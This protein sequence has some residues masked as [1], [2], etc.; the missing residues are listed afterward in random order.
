MLNQSSSAGISPL[1]TPV[2]QR[3]IKDPTSYKTEKILVTPDIA[4]EWLTTRFYSGQ[5]SLRSQWVNYLSEEM[6]KGNFLQGTAVHFSVEGPEN[7]VMLI[8]GQHTLSAI[9][10]CKIPQLLTT[11]YI[12]SEGKDQTAQYYYSIDMQARR[13]ATDM[14]SAINLADELVIPQSLLGKLSAAV[15]MI[16]SKFI[17]YRNEN[18]H[19]DDVLRL[20]RE[21][22]ESMNRYMDCISGASSNMKHLAFRRATLSVALV[23]FHFSSKRVGDEKIID[24]WKGVIID[25]AIGKDDVR[26]I[27]NRHLQTSVSPTENKP[28]STKKTVSY[29]YSARYIAKCFNWFVSEHKPSEKTPSFFQVDPMS[30]IK[31]VGSPFVGNQ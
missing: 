15:K 9:I 1:F 25:D 7:K 5:R 14:F 18:F 22:S 17:P 31:I 10:N 24:F 8:N 23:T 13:T 21:Y 29:I 2:S 20:M 4:R 19:S 16:D 3:L 28:I 26:K 30:P 11:I 27:A 12:S 6:S